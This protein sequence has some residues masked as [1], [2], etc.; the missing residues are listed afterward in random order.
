M[1]PNGLIHE[2]RTSDINQANNPILFNIVSAFST[3]VGEFSKLNNNYLI[4]NII[5]NPAFKRG[6]M[7]NR[8]LDSNFFTRTFYTENLQSLRTLTFSDCYHNGS[9]K[10]LG[11]FRAMGLSVP[12]TASYIRG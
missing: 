11:E 7:E 9:F 1:S 10:D 5:D 8:L 2:I 3:F 4:A 12:D 6:P